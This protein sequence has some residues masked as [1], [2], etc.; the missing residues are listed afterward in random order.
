LAAEHGLVADALK[1]P[2][3]ELLVVPF[4]VHVAGV[5]EGHT[6]ID[7][8]PD[9]RDR[10]T[11]VALGLGVRPAHAHASQAH[12]ADVPIR[13]LPHGGVP[14]RIGRPTTLA[15]TNR[16]PTAPRPTADP[17]ITCPIGV[18]ESRQADRLVYALAP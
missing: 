10:L 13:E 1:C 4:A 14:F 18:R 8:L 17:G 6:E 16:K 7:R 9:Q 5:Q 2:A 15:A 3:Q 12:R 11:V